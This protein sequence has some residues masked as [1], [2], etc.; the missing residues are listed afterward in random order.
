MACGAWCNPEA[1]TC[2][3]SS[4]LYSQDAQYVL[5]GSDDANVRLWKSNA[6][7]VMGVMHPV[8]RD[9]HDY[10]ARLKKRYSHLP[11]I[12]RIATHRNVPKPVYS[13]RRIK[14]QML[15]AQQLKLRK[16]RAHRGG[17]ERYPVVSEK[18]AI[19]QGVLE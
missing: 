4:V 17:A 7:K 12:R 3:S 2:C 19:A 15:A 13:A 11:E 10:Q 9:K 16:M 14:K 6:S 5:S 1:L 18:K 8:E